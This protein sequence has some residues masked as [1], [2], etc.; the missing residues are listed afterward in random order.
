MNNGIKNIKKG[1]RFKSVNF[2]EVRTGDVIATK[3]KKI[4]IRNTE[5]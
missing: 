3:N 5:N 1:F 2:R 4:K